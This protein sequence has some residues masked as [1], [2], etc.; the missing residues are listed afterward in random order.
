MVLPKRLITDNGTHFNNH[1]LQAITTSMHIGHAFSVTYHPQTNGQVERFNATFAAQLAKYF[2][3]DRNDWDLYLPSIVYAYNTSVHATTNLI[4]YEVAFARRPKSPFDPMSP[5][6][7]LPPAHSFHR[8]LQRTRQVLT[9]QARHNIHLQQ[10]RWRHR[11]NRNRSNPSYH[12]G[13]QVYV[14]VSS[15]RAKLDSRRFGPCTVLQISGDQTYL[16][17]DN[18]TGRTKSAHVNQ[19]HPVIQRSLS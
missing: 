4:P 1:L 17:Q 14:N 8:S 10:S 9:D 11:Y 15:G 12:V 5:T 3:P 7:D 16:V 19:L 2:D 13:S 6:I 18:A